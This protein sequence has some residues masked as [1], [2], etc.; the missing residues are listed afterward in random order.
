MRERNLGFEATRP[1]LTVAYCPA[2]DLAAEVFGFLDRLRRDAAVELTD[3]PTDAA[4]AD[5]A[6]P[7]PPLVDIDK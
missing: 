6:R 4:H 1:R 3:R 5:C 7:A 2:K